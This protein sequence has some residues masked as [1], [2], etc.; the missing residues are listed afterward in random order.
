MRYIL[1]ILA[2][3]GLAAYGENS[4][5]PDLTPLPQ[6]SQ[7]S[8]AWGTNAHSQMSGH[9]AGYT[10]TIGVLATRGLLP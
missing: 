7:A 5:L 9:D 1:T 4:K 6:I 2:L 10:D 8:I 3:V